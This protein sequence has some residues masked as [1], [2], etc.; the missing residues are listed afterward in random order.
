MGVVNFPGIRFSCSLG[1]WVVAEDAVRIPGDEEVPAPHPDERDHVHLLDN[2]PQPEAADMREEGDG[3][4]IPP[5][6][7][8][9]EGAS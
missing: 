3:A 1:G 9:G 8:V 7:A 5:A 2:P 4:P 6:P